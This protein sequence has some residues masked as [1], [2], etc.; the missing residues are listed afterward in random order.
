MSDVHLYERASGSFA[1]SLAK[2]GHH[3]VYRANA[4]NHCP[5]CGRS[6]WYVGR[7]SAE[8]GFCGAAVPLAETSLREAPQPSSRAA[9]VSPS[10]D[11]RR[12]PRMAVK[13]RE[14]QLLIDGSPNSFAIHNISEGGVM[15][16]LIPDLPLG[17]KVHVRFEGGILVPAVVKWVENGLVGLAFLDSVVLDRSDE[18]RH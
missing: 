1:A 16:D 7:L 14:L 2:R 12:Y 6:Q 8:C 13:D 3:I 11:Q 18:P 9:N 17:A 15:G 10:A 5:G 4:A